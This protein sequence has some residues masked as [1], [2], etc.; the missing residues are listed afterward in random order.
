MKSIVEKLRTTVEEKMAVVEETV[1]SFEHVER[2]FKIATHL[3]IQEG[4]YLEL[5]QV[6]AL[7][8]DIG[9]T[10]GKPHHETGAELAREILKKMDY[11]SEETIVSIVLHHHLDCKD[12]LRTL[13]EK[14]VWDADKIDLLGIL[15]IVRTF[16]LLGNQPFDSVVQRAFKEL[17]TV[18]P[19]LNTTT[20]KII[21]EK[22]QK[23]TL[24]LLVA[25]K[26]ELLL[27]DLHLSS[28][29]LT[30]WKKNQVSVNCLSRTR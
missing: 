30:Q 29:N 2:V 8:H 1:H 10:V 17:K 26:E 25:L 27:E 16:H 18:Y 11:P 3:A 15:G 12:K 20:A 13:E 22:R 28:N 5:V 14:V 19:L 9:W 23:E 4:A 21:A 7:L 6:G 24:F